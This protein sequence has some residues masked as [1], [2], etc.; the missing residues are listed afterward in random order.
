[1]SES[2]GPGQ[3]ILAAD[4]AAFKAG[5]WRGMQFGQPIDCPGN[6]S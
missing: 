5:R 2:G 6:L 3:R 1:M 4:A